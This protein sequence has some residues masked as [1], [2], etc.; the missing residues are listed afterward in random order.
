VRGGRKAWSLGKGLGGGGGTAGLEIESDVELEAV[1][2]GVIDAAAG[3]AGAKN[4]AAD[5]AA[6]AAKSSEAPFES[7]GYTS[8]FVSKDVADSGD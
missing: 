8:G 5:G 1:G 3:G 7:F 4:L 6:L 2:I